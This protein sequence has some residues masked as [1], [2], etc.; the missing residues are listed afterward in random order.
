MSAMRSPGCLSSRRALSK[1]LRG[2]GSGPARMTTFLRAHERVDRVLER[3]EPGRVDD[4]HLAEVED[5]DLEASLRAR[6][7]RLH[8]ALRGA[9]EERA[10]RSRRARRPGEARPSADLVVV[11]ERR[12]SA[13]GQL[14]HARMKSTAARTTPDR[15]GDHHVEEDGE[16]EA[17]EQHEDVALRRDLARCRRSC[18]APTCSTRRAAAAPRATPSART[19]RAARGRASTS[20][21]KMR[22]RHRRRSGER[23][24]ARMLVAV[25]AS[26]PVA[27]IPP[28]NGRDDV[29]DAEADELRVRVVLGAGHA[30]GDDGREQRLDRAE[31]RDG[32]RRREELAQQLQGE[33]AAPTGSDG[34]GSDRRDAGDVDAV[35]DRVKAAAD[36][37]D[38]ETRDELC[39]SGR[40]A[41]TSAIAMSGAGIRLVTRGN[42]EEQRERRAPRRR[43]RAS[44]PSRARPRARELLDV[45]IGH[46]PDAAG[47]RRP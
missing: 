28:K 44:W 36:R 12:A 43:P 8:R 6:V 1:T 22:V 38:G 20:S 46:R 34:V 41:A 27:A 25:R 37:R 45:A 32:E 3:G 5:H 42:R 47:R 39:T 2:W 23:A 31:H 26:A 24:P 18:G 4:R 33:P 40:D 15:H 30:V 35:D 13:L 29:A 7:E 21:T 14:R 11:V 19:R 9:E 10:V 17:R 16:H